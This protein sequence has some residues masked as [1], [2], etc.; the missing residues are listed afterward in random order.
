MCTNYILH[1]TLNKTRKLE[2]EALKHMEY[3]IY[4]FV[5]KEQSFMS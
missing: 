3:N 2:N 4:F 1:F 5:Y